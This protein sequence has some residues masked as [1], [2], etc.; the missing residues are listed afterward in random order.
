M[1]NSVCFIESNDTELDYVN[2]VLIKYVLINNVM[3][4]NMLL[5]QSMHNIMI[6]RTITI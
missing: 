2:K 5:Y 1:L 3:I 6:L 4:Q